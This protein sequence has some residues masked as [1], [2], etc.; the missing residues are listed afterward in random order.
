MAAGSAEAE[1]RVKGSRFIAI[2]RPVS[3]L[4]QAAGYREAE[5][6]RFHDATH[7]V[8]AA[9]LGGGD[10]RFDDDGDPSGT[11]GRPTLAAIERAG[12]SD[13]A[14]IVTRYFGGTRLG[15]G[16][17]GRAYGEAADLAL[18]RTAART[19]VPGRRVLLKYSYADTG[20]VTRSVEAN[21]ATRLHE[22]YGD[23]AE[24][25]VALPA[26]RVD[27]LRAEV[28]EATGGR[29]ELV[30]LPGEMLLPVDT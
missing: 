27:V 26:A 3:D 6:R 30:E 1:Y 12:L 22:R 15:T 4:A 14:V 16:G 8:Y 20:A 21:G 19:V 13:V 17:L 28:T 24:L 9:L 5:R 7:H 18:E 29:T 10:Q 2:T 23:L 25:E 11:A